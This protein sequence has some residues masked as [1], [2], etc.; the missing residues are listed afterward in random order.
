MY[1]VSVSC[2]LFLLFLF[3]A[4]NKMFY[5]CSLYRGL[6][7]TEYIMYAQ[8]IHVAKQGLIIILLGLRE[9]GIRQFSLYGHDTILEIFGSGGGVGDQS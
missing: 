3:L 5:S 1:V 2:I 9:K 4:I 8:A 7:C 6:N